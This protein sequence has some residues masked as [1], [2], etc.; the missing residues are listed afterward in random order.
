MTNRGARE[1]G[2]EYERKI[3]RAF[4]DALKLERHQCYRTPMSG[5][6]AAASKTAP[7]DLQFDPAVDA[8]LLI[9]VEC[10]NQAIARLSHLHS[11]RGGKYWDDWLVQACRAATDNRLPILVA[12][13][14][15]I[16]FAIWPMSDPELCV[17]RPI[18]WRADRGGPRAAPSSTTAPRARIPGS[19]AYA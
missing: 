17:T 14:D 18:A 4:R 19:T 11:G 12:R 5:G 3:A 13:V 15:R 7:G 2:A 16:D 1:K 9:S 10:K 6:H 8:A